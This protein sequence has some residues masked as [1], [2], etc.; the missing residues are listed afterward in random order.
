[1]GM[2]LV[3]NILVGYV[4]VG[5]ILM[6]NILG[7]QKGV[8]AHL[9]QGTTAFTGQAWVQFTA[10]GNILKVLNEFQILLRS[11]LSFEVIKVSFDLSRT[12]FFDK[13]FVIP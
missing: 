1:M 12:E 4:S 2:V 9:R 6:G 5:N 13:K 7:L 3:G 11:S 8:Q 10:I